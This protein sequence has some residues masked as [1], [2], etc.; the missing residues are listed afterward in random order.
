MIRP[1]TRALR[2]VAPL[3]A[4]LLF[5]AACGSSAAVNWSYAPPTTTPAASGS[6]AASASASP[7]SS[8][9]VSPG[10][11]GSGGSGSGSVIDLTETA[12]LRIVDA[13]GQQVSSID[14]TKGET[15]TFNITNTA[16]YDHDFYIGSPADLQAGNTANLT[17]IAPFSSGTKTFTYTF[18]SSGT[19]GFGCTIPGHYQTM[20]GTFN[21]QG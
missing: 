3:S 12:D 16:G 13:S 4:A 21:V 2:A 8:A 20:H 11:S 5:I 19:L 7:G 9:S 14:V 17:G 15:Y 10:T 6:A 18:Q 1:V